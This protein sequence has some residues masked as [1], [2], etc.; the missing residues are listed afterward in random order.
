MATKKWPR[1]TSTSGCIFE[2]TTNSL[3]QPVLVWVDGSRSMM[4]WEYGEGFA[5]AVTPTL[6]FN[7]AD[8]AKIRKWAKG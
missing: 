6:I 1:V 8:A 7:K 4:H 5:A 2:L 3:G